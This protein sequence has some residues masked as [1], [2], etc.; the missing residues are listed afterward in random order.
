MR[1][2]VR[3]RGRNHRQREYLLDRGQ[4]RQRSRRGRCLRRLAHCPG[5]DAGPADNHP[6]ER[7]RALV[8]EERSGLRRTV[9]QVGI[10]FTQVSARGERCVI[11]VVRGNHLVAITV[12][13]YTA[14]DRRNKLER[15]RCPVPLGVAVPA[16][17]VTVPNLRQPGATVQPGAQDRNRRAAVGLEFTLCVVGDHPAEPREQRPPQLAVRAVLGEHTLC[18]LVGVQRQRRDDEFL[19]MQHRL[20]LGSKIHCGPHFEQAA[21]IQLAAP[22]QHARSSDQPKVGLAIGAKVRRGSGDEG[23]SDASGS[24]QHHRSKHDPRERNDNATEAG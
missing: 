3:R 18:A 23:K 17:I 21:L 8:P 1:N 11:D 7:L 13:A 22:R 24:E 5:I 16:T 20:L 10:P 2:P 6:H 14:P 15:T 19:R 12:R 9:S 4:D